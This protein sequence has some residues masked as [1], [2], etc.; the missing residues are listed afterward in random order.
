MDDINQ[1]ISYLE[2][3]DKE[4]QKTIDEM[5]GTIKESTNKKLQWLIL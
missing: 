5:N 3:S 1:K 4:F 2:K